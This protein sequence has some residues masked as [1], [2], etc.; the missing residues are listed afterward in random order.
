VLGRAW[1]VELFGW[2]LGVRFGQKDS[3]SWIALL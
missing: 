2:N 3:R 1:I